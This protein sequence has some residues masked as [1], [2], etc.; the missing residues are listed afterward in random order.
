MEQE[1]A[2]ET[3]GRRLVYFAAERTLMAWLRTALSL[4]ALG[5][6]LD[7]FELFLELSLSEA[8]D[9]GSPSPHAWLGIP[10]VVIGAAMAATAAARYAAFAIGYRRERR[11]EPG[12][13]L[14]VGSAFA[15][16]VALAGL[17]LA[18]YLFRLVR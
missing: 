10:L 7:R 1:T 5:F 11:T 17:A 15:V 9:A 3:S 6:V 13:G 16:V 18:Y 12:H 14:L 2:S 4:M 8:S